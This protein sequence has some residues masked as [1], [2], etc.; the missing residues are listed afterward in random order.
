[1]YACM[2]EERHQWNKTE[3]WLV[4]YSYKKNLAIFYEKIPKLFVEF[5][6]LNIY[7]RLARHLNVLSQMK[8]SL[9]KIKQA[10]RCGMYAKICSWVGLVVV[11]FSY[12]SST[13]YISF[14]YGKQNI[15]QVSFCIKVEC[16]YGIV[17]EI[18]SLKEN[19]SK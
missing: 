7:K 4:V 17:T 16:W 13:P 18:H 1:M 15:K 6:C 3:I 8:L 10:N 11:K 2:H 12:W 19:D 14:R 5:H 9:A